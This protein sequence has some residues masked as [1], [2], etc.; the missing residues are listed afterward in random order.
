MIRCIGMIR[1]AIRGML[2]YGHYELDIMGWT[3]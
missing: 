2:G 1:I 3:L